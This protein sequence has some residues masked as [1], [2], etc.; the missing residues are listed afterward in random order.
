VAQSDERLVL[1][2]VASTTVL[3]R[4]ADRTERTEGFWQHEV[5]ASKLGDTVLVLLVPEADRVVD[6][7]RRSYDPSALEGMAAHITIL[8][9]FI[10]E[11][12]IDEATTKALAAIAAATPTFTVSFERL[13]R[14]PGVL[15]LDPASSAVLELATEVH[16]HWPECIPYRDP[17]L[18]VVPHLTVTSKADERTVVLIE[19]D[20]VSRLPI[21][22]G[23]EAM[24][25]MAFD[26]AVWACRDRFPFGPKGA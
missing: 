11:H 1:T 6:S 16:R 13:G 3:N 19:R 10:P 4:R 15:W 14:F 24:S 5:V 26:G 17:D 9:P 2:S 8:G 22:A 23:I 21:R 12:E 20:L 18:E 7:W 25:L